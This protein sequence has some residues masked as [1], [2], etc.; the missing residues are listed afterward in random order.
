MGKMR[1]FVENTSFRYKIG[2]VVITCPY[3]ATLSFR[4]SDRSMEYFHVT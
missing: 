3:L 1:S 4:I 2:G